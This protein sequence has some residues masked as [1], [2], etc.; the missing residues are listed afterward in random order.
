MNTK[1]KHKPIILASQSPRRADLLGKA[2]I[3]FEAVH[4]KLQEPPPQFGHYSP[5]EY[6]EAASYFKARSVTDHYPGRL[7][8]AADTVVSL[9]GEII[10]KPTD[11]NDAR[12]I[13]NTL[14]GT[15]HEV[16]TGV[17]LYESDTDR[18]IINHATTKVTL[19]KMTDRELDDYIASGEWAGKAG[20]YAIQENADKFVTKTEGSFTN[21][22]GL[23][24]EMLKEMLAQ[25]DIQPSNK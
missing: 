5:A 18:R 23:P 6:A 4:P 16:I 17:T 9:G 8:L 24:M 25:F 19:R 13:L 22:I 11:E 1:T 7:V 10:G 21:I 12:R 3:A 14:T 15:T 2:G 20:A